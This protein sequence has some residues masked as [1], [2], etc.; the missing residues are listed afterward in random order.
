MRT[1][2]DEIDGKETSLDTRNLSTSMDGKYLW[3]VMHTMVEMAK[4]NP[5]EM[6]DSSFVYE[7]SGG[8]VVEAVRTIHNIFALNKAGPLDLETWKDASWKAVSFAGGLSDYNKMMLAEGMS[9]SGKGIGY[10]QTRGEALARMFGVPPSEEMLLHMAMVSPIQRQKHV[11]ELAKKI[12]TETI[13]HIKAVSP[14]EIEKQTIYFDTLGAFLQGVDPAYKEE[15]TNEVFK[16]DK[17]NLLSKKESLYIN[18]YNSHMMESDKYY[19]D[20]RNALERSNDPKAQSLLKDLE[21]NKE[22]SVK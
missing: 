21:A 19:I 17:Y 13:A 12:H 7:S 1:L 11:K 18:L 22:W 6:P 2:F 3:E 5:A 20:L 8:A 9:K 16:M 15:V 14:D 10:E 4:G